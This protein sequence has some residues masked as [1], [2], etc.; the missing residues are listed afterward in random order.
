[1]IY[2]F[3]GGDQNKVRAK[4]SAWISAVKEKQPHV[5]YIRFTPDTFSSE[6]LGNLL[7]SNPLFGEKLLI[8]ID[9]LL[10]D[11]DTREAARGFLG[12]LAESDHVAV[13]IDSALSKKDQEQIGKVAEKVFL[14][15]T[16]KEAAKDWS[17]FEVANAIARKDV[18]GAWV[19]YISQRK[20]GDEPEMLA[21][22]MH[23]KVR[24][25]TQ[26]NPREWSGFSMALLEAYNGSRR[27]EWEL[28]AALEHALLTKMP[29]KSS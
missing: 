8:S 16:R 23:A 9:G 7:S 29:Q 17:A 12:A 20:K 27:G 15:E 1:M 21:G 18:R 2:A 3:I 25:L 10:S 11:T 28:D 14:Y 22:I 4:A 19:A 26:Q 13:L 6:E 24:K 5:T